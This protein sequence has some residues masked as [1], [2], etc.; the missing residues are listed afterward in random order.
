MTPDQVK[1][2]QASF[3]KVAPMIGEAY[4]HSAAAE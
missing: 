3:A 4:G 2:I 1:T